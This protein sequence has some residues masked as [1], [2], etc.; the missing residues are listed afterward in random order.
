MTK[1][2]FDKI[3]AVLKTPISK[4]SK[5]KPSL[6]DYPPELRGFSNNRFGGHK[7]QSL[8]GF[9]GNTYGPAGP[10]RHFTENET[11]EYEKAMREQGLI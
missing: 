9:K 1:T 3:K 10:V 8:R 5:R 4:N 6:T 2:K 7:A 11:R